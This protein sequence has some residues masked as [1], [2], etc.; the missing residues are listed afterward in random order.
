L[1]GITLAMESR[2]SRCAATSVDPRT[3]RRDMQI[4]KALATHF[5]HTDFGI[6]AVARTSGAI[7]IGDAV[8][9]GSAVS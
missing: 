3:G 4:P 1:P 7:R 8:E 9:T 2:T 5:G 6:Y